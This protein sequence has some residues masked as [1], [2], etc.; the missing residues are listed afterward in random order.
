MKFCMKMKK[1]KESLFPLSATMFSVFISDSRHS[2]PLKWGGRHLTFDE[3]TAE[4]ES[5]W[6]EYY[7]E[8]LDPW[9]EDRPLKRD[10]Y[11]RVSCWSLVETGPLFTFGFQ[12]KDKQGD[13]TLK[14][15]SNGVIPRGIKKQLK[16][17]AAALKL[18]SDCVGFG[19]IDG[20]E[21]IV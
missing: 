20:V 17:V 9:C 19:I 2:E 15:F 4:L 7:A 5:L 1:V 3:C 6:K 10:S 21:V 8:K 11:V 14:F 12:N 18:Y 13:K 16:V